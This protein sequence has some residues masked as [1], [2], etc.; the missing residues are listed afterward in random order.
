LEHLTV[1]KKSI[2]HQFEDLALIHGGFL[3]HLRMGGGHGMGEENLGQ[4]I[5]EM[6]DGGEMCTRKKKV[7]VEMSVI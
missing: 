2:D 4:R 6:R 7:V 5:G 3:E 1:R